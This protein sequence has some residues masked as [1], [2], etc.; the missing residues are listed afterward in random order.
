M[1]CNPSDDPAPC[2][3]GEAAA[4]GIVR[5]LTSRA[6]RACDDAACIEREVQNVV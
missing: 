1:W 3:S 4:E 5:Q 2:D 6:I